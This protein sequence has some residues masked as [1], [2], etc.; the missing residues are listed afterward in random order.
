MCVRVAAKCR[1]LRMSGA[2]RSGPPR[3]SVSGRWELAQYTILASSCAQVPSG[4]IYVYAYRLRRRIERVTS[5]LEHGTFRAP[6]CEI[7]VSFWDS[8]TNFESTSLHD[9]IDQIDDSAVVLVDY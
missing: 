4:A 9:V 6:R 1:C 3:E 2:D 5:V 8:V 7:T